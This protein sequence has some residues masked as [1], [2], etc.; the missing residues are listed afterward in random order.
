MVEHVDDTQILTVAL[1]ATG[2]LV[3]PIDLEWIRVNYDTN[4]SGYIEE[5]EVSVA[6]VDLDGG[7]IT[8]EQY[9]AVEKAWKDHTPL[10]KVT[11]GV[12]CSTSCDLLLEYDKN[13]DGII[14]ETETHVAATAAAKGIISNVQSKFINDAHVAGSI[15]AKCPG[16]Y[17][18][19]APLPPPTPKPTPPPAPPES[20]GDPTTVAHQYSLEEGEYSITVTKSDYETVNARIKVLS[21][22]DVS[23]ED[24]TGV[25]ECGTGYPRVET[26]GSSVRVY[27]EYSG[28][29]AP[30]SGGVCDW[31]VSL[32]GWRAITWD[33]VLDIYDA[34]LDPTQ[35]SIGFDVVWEDVLTTYDY[36]LDQPSGQPTAGNASAHGCGFT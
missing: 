27:M 28:G 31:I 20:A 29:E 12:N 33:D 16:C 34:Y 7:E 30:M 36:Y 18:G 11:E 15:N 32:G 5:G 8:T 21:N 9:D 3:A 17:T 2:G 35:H 19:S 22:G 10:E 4:R 26:V 24:V 23:C 6:G 1:K 14:D 25:Y 13:N